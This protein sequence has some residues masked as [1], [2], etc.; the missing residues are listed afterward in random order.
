[1]LSSGRFIG[2]QN[3]NLM[4]LL[5]PLALV[6][7]PLYLFAHPSTPVHFIEGNLA[8]VQQLA[9][10]EGKL[11]FIHFAADWCMT[12]QWMEEH[13]FT[14]ASLSAYLEEHYLALRADVDLPEG[15]ALKGQYEVSIL[16]SILVFSSRGQL[17]GRHEGA[18]EPE[19]LLAH[20][21]RY[22]R[23]ALA[24]GALEENILSS[25]RPVFALSRPALI[26]D[27]QARPVA[28][29]PSRPAVSI[30]PAGYSTPPQPLQPKFTIQVGVFSSYSN[31]VRFCAAL[32]A[33]AAH[34]VE[35][36]P[37]QLNGQSMYKVL[38]GQFERQEAAAACLEGLRAQKV[39]G[40]V[41]ILDN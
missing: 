19:E 2:P 13:A 35:V 24:S 40:F 36:A 41:K 29:P 26:P 12:S 6:C 21:K 34:R 7:L 31:A 17:L 4:K 23:P 15:R 18:M 11:Y 39:E 38:L 20:L 1:M 37:F 27:V 16:P 10:R 22:S 32:E 28:L 5:A 3:Y 8:Q 25:P 14:D 30:P 33:K 9:A